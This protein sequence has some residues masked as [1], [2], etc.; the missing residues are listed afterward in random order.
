MHWDSL[1][2]GKKNFDKRLLVFKII[3]PYKINEFLL[4]IKNTDARKKNRSEDGLRKYGCYFN[5][6]SLCGVSLAVH[7]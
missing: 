2:F 6:I 5:S 1:I 4:L 3:K 7:I